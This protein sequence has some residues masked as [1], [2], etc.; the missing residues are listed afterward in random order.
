MSVPVTRSRALAGL[1]HGFFGRRGGH[2]VGE[3]ASLNV[4]EA[5]GDAAD[6]VARNRG[7]AAAALGLPAQGLMLLRQVHSAQVVTLDAPFGAE[8]PQADGMVTATPGLVL[9]ILTADCAPVLL[10]DPA[11]G[12]IGAFHAGWRGA[13]AG[14]AEATVAAMEALGADRERI[15]AAIGPTI[16][17]ANYE[18]GPEFVDEV[19]AQYRD[20]GSRIAAPPGERARFDLPGFVFDRLYEA[21]VGAVEDL[22]LCTY[23]EPKRYFSHRFATHA[24]ARTGRQIALI[25]LG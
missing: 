13:V 16:S 10:A 4:S 12:V 8:R 6:V 24:G 18:V 5:V 21:G 3:F 25:G 7:E 22:G 1:R 9:A 23:A 15:L 11:A 2:S 19:L 20:A 17:Q 14:I